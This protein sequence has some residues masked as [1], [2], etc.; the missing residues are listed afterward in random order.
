MVEY[1]DACRSLVLPADPTGKAK[2]G[3]EVKPPDINLSDVAFTVVYGPGE[4]RRADTGHI[5]FGLSAV[6]GVGE[7]AITSVIAERSKN[8][9]FR[10]LFDFCERVDLR[11]CNKATLEA[12]IK[13]GAFDGLHGIEKAGRLLGR[14]RRRDALGPAGRG[15][16]GIRPDGDVR[17]GAGAV[18]GGHARGPGRGA[19]APVVRAVDEEADARVREGR[20]GDVRLQPPAQRPRRRAAQLQLLRDR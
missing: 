11:A 3:V 8:G 19:R 5:R 7:K 15:G 17:R 2:K 10:G 6:K 14:A 16:Q 13:C 4:E 12:L 18:R 9:P 1:I 20:D